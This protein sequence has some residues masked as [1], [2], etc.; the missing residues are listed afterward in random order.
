MNFHM[1]KRKLAGPLA[2]GVLAGV[3][4]GTSTA[5]AEGSLERVS[6]PNLKPYTI[7]DGTSIPKSFT[8]KPGNAANGK[9]LFVHRKKGNCLTCH[10]API[11]EEEFHGKVAPDLDGVGDRMTE[12]EIRLRIV[13][14]KLS[15]PDT[16]MMAYYKTH[17]LNQVNKKFVGK[18]MLNEQELEDVVAYLVSLK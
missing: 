6:E 16:P 8:G 9:K 13:N 4:F 3:A 2:W 5:L 10:T 17:G 14:P 1:M 7:V 15:N 11:P 18:P 12:G